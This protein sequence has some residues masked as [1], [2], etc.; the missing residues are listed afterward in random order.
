[1]S[2]EPSMDIPHSCAYG[3]GA[4]AR[5]RSST[6]GSDV[7]VS[8]PEVALHVIS[9]SAAFEK[10]RT[11]AESRSDASDRCCRKRIL[12]GGRRKIDSKRAPPTFSTVSTHF[13]HRAGRETDRRP[14]PAEKRSNLTGSSPKT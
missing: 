10:Q 14:S 3:T 4:A 11:S 5:F 13:R 1:M 7:V 9:R 2:I 8:R 12:R 6:S